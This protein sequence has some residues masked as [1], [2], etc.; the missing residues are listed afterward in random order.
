MATGYLGDRDPTAAS[1]PTSCPLHRDSPKTVALSLT[2]ILQVR[3]SRKVV[4]SPL[5]CPLWGLHS[6]LSCGDAESGGGMGS[7]EELPGQMARPCGL[8]GLEGLRRGCWTGP[9]TGV[10]CTHPRPGQLSSPAPRFQPHAPLPYVFGASSWRG[11]QDKA[12][13][14]QQPP[15]LVHARSQAP[16]PLSA[17]QA[18]PRGR[19]TA[20]GAVSAVRNPATPEAAR[21]PGREGE[22]LSLL[23]NFFPNV[24]AAGRSRG[25]GQRETPRE[26]VWPLPAGSG[27]P[28]G[29]GF[30]T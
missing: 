17:H 30:R 15:S 27:R 5:P 1:G 28:G 21:R 2:V 14:L 7:G 4:T 12:F 6:P 24:P 29:C 25:G 9:R 23:W 26:A 20:Q 18:T 22:L 19:D 3:E 11:T 16:L 13:T 10:L 8:V